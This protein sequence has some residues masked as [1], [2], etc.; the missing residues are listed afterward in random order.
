MEYIIKTETLNTGG[1]CMV[2]ALTLHDGRVIL[3][4]DEYI[5]LYESLDS[6]F[7]DDFGLACIN[8]FWLDDDKRAL[9]SL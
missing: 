7:N 4:S 5:G 3:I 1:N 2:D 6:F 8:G 9:Y